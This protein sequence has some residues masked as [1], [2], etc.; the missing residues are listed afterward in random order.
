MTALLHILAHLL[1]F[2]QPMWRSTISSQMMNGV[3]TLRMIRDHHLLVSSNAT[4]VYISSTICFVTSDDEYLPQIENL[5]RK[6]KHHRSFLK[7]LY[8]E[9]QGMRL[10]WPPVI[11]MDF[12][13]VFSIE[14][15]NE[16]DEEVTAHLVRGHL[17]K[18]RKTRTPIKLS[19]IASMK[20]GSRPKCIIVQGAPGSGKTMFSW[21]LCRRWGRGELLG[22]YPLVIML[23]LRD[24]DIQNASSMEDLFPH[25]DKPIKQEVTA[26]VKQE[27]GEGVLFVLDGFDELPA[28][29]RSKFSFWMKLINGEVLMRA[30]VMVTSRPWAIKPLLELKYS[31]TRISQHVEI[32]GFDNDSIKDYIMKAFEDCTKQKSFCE[33]LTRYPQ[34]Q[35]IMYVPLNCATVVWLFKLSGSTNPAPKTITQ[36]YKELVKTLLRRYMDSHPEGPTVDN[37]THPSGIAPCERKVDFLNDLPFSVYQQL[38]NINRLAYQ[39]LCNNQQ[40]IFYDLPANFETLGLLQEV[41]QFYLPGKSSTSYN[42][43]H[44]TV[45]EFLAAL[46]IVQQGTREQE[47]VVSGEVVFR[48]FPVNEGEEKLGDCDNDTNS[49]FSE[50]DE[51]GQGEMETGRSFVRVFVAGLSGL[52]QCKLL[53]PEHCGEEDIALLHVLF[54]AQN[55]NLITSLLGNESTIRT[56]RS[57]HVSPHD[58]YVLGFCISLS[59]CQWELELFSMG[60]EQIYMMNQAID[61]WGYGKGRITRIELYG[62][63]LSSDG[64]SLL[65]PL[66]KHTFSRLWDL[67]IGSYELDSKLC[68][69]LAN[70]LSS[71]PHLEM[72]HLGGNEIGAEGA[73]QLSQTLHTNGT[74]TVLNLSHNDIGDRGVGS[75][76]KA[77]NV[78]TCLE[79]LDLSF[80]QIGSEGARLI[81][82]S[83]HTNTTL[84]GLDLSNNDIRDVGATVLAEAL[85]VN[86]C[87]ENLDLTFNQIRFEGAQMLSRSLHTNATLRE[88]NLSQNNIDNRGGCSLADAL[89]INEGLKVLDLSGN[90]LGE[91]SIQQLIDSLQH[92]YT[93]RKLRLLLLWKEFS[94]QCGWWNEVKSRVDFY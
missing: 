34:I 55:E 57:Q 86:T 71:L 7:K 77:L 74:L 58:A 94:Q 20:D 87:L 61:S 48:V 19:N 54:E 60:D 85:N 72:L 53:I 5:S 24:L 16:A 15:T 36:L 40:L 38:C 22:Q 76:A 93:L 47:K 88:L 6:V 63:E 80:N 50:S 45:Q 42:F 29:K 91:K 8:K 92:N 30:T 62:D 2:P 28:E 66:P 9:R 27:A 59:R 46:H 18:V 33:Y 90:P 56:V 70:C 4:I 39:G 3:V 32:V 75:L 82:Q 35:S 1:S 52:K 11:M 69:K 78:N 14:W 26:A 64:I 84:R 25:D 51:S 79:K 49:S 17:E 44:L 31:S 41:P 68:E 43:L 37:T 21:E 23:P 83:L 12:V 81:S 73:H 67:T 89:S 13:N 65:L 10:K